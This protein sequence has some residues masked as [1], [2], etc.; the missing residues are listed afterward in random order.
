MANI[1]LVAALSNKRNGYCCYCELPMT[2]LNPETVLPS[3]ETREHKVPKGHNGHNGLC[4]LDAACSR[5][6][7]FRGTM[8]PELYTKI[9]RRLFQDPD[10]VEAWH[11]KDPIVTKLLRKVFRLQ[12]LYAYAFINARHA[13]AY[14]EAIEKSRAGRS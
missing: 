12:V 2:R 8:N 4:N 14:L 1:E 6:N 13:F 10:I 5:C 11:Y 9:V 7:G 3:S